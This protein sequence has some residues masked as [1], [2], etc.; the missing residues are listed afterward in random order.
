MYGDDPFL[1]RLL[2]ETGWFLVFHL[3]VILEA[4]HD[5][6]K[7]E[8]WFTVAAGGAKGAPADRHI[9]VHFSR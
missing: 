5:P 8:T 3:A 9:G 7:R 4:S 1:V 2:I 6:A